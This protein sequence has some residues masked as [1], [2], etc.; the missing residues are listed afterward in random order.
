MVGEIGV[1]TPVEK[2]LVNLFQIMGPVLSYYGLTWGKGGSILVR[3]I[4]RA[5]PSGVQDKLGK[6]TFN[7]RDG[8]I[9]QFGEDEREFQ[10]KPAWDI[11]L[12]RSR[13]Y[14]RYPDGRR[15]IFNE[16]DLEG[17]ARFIL[18]TLGSLVGDGG[19]KATRRRRVVRRKICRYVWQSLN[20]VNE[21][22]AGRGQ[23]ARVWTHNIM[24]ELC[25]AGQA[26]G[27]DVCT[28]GGVTQANSPGW[29]FD[30]VWLD[31]IPTP[32]QLKRISLVVECEWGMTCEE[33]FYD[34]EKLLVARADVRL[35]IFQARNAER[36]NELFDGMEEEARDFYQSQPGDYYMLVGYDNAESV[37]LRRQFSI[38][39]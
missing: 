38:S 22:L 9:I 39:S 10:I 26:L 33:I 30:Q 3:H 21:R 19:G 20:R 13:F 11:S 7:R 14:V 1:P 5:G 25:N 4:C 35:M 36:V 6:I 34:F 16:E 28:T 2:V 24:S 8:I 23:G 17:V 12:A 32:R 37:F 18:Y 15:L 29:L 27:Y 31:W